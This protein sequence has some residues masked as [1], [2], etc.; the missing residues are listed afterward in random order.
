MDESV[1]FGQ[2]VLADR[3]DCLRVKT[4]PYSKQGSL[5]FSIRRKNNNIL[6]RFLFMLRFTFSM[7]SIPYFLFSIQDFHA[8]QPSKQ[9]GPPR[10]QTVF[11]PL[12]I[13]EITS[14]LLYDLY[15]LFP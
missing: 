15:L 4:I 14:S 6:A 11:S 10:F 2:N 5:L 7:I 9:M 8:S 3:D 13:S 1:G 12:E